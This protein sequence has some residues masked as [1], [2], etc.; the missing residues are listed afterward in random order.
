MQ[1]NIKVE[2]LST[3]EYQISITVP[4]SAVD[5][6]FDEFFESIKSKAQ[7]PGFRK[8]KAPVAMLKQYFSSKAKAP[9]AGLL[10]SEFYDKAIKQN[11]LVPL[12]TPTIKDFNAGSEYPG[13][14]GFDNSYE[15]AFLVEVSPKVDPIGYKE[16]ELEMA[17]VPETAMI[18]HHLHEYRDRFAERTQVLDRGANLGDTLIVDFV[19]CLNNVP[20]EGGSAKGH[21]LDK[22]GQGT[23]IPG[24]E[25]QLLGM[26][27]GETK[28]IF[29]TFPKEYHAKQLEGKDATF[30][31]TVHSIV[32]TK[33][34]D[35]NDDLAMMAGFNNL[36]ELKANIAKEVKQEQKAIVRQRMDHQIMTKLLEAN[37]FDAPK[38]L[39]DA[40][41]KHIMSRIKADNIPDE[42]K[43]E[44]RKNAEFNVRRALIANAIYEKEPSIEVTPEE[45][46]IK[47]EEQAKQS[48]KTKD[49]VISALYNSNQMDN[50]V[51]VIRFTKVIDFIIDNAKKQEKKVEE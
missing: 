5:Q 14:F 1:E 23:L 10:A 2:A 44:L 16:M 11:D 51:G 21:T 35:E 3:T 9:V 39:V 41:F 20:F 19:G 49:E 26:K 7:I 32:A 40:E 46:D 43:A 13:K 42:F 31:V 37:K 4:P 15:I 22:L 6:K 12:G 17:E 8:G 34:A 25:E 33:L 50:F 47:L 45:L 38:K 29:V 48:N 36:E 24:F 30:D 28:K 18:N 27:V